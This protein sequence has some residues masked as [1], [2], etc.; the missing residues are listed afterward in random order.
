VT[1]GEVLDF[2][3]TTI[4]AGEWY[5]LDL[6]YG[7]KTVLDNS[8]ANVVSDLS[9]DSDLATWHLATDPEAAGGINSI[10]VTGSAVTEATSV[11]LV[12]FERYLGI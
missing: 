12:W 11:H 7:Y 2:T 10:T 1:T 4:G 9:S 8:G 6:R 3:G 5:E